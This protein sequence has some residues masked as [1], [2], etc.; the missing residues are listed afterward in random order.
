MVSLAFDGKTLR[1]SRTASLSDGD[2]GKYMECLGYNEEIHVP[3][4]FSRN[5]IHREFAV[6]GIEY[7]VNN[8]DKMPKLVNY[9][10]SENVTMY[11]FM[12]MLA[13]EA[14][15]NLYDVK[16]KSK[17]DDTLTPRP[18]KGGFNVSLAKSLGF[19]MFNLSDTVSRLGKDY[20]G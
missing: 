7:M 2:I 17:Y 8:W 4:F 10:G 20:Y 13:M 16:K 19:P 9:A 5:Y 14:G 15:M 18:R 1:L 3:D 12:R 11:A 6:D